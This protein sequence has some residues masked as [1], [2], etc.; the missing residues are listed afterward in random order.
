MSRDLN[1][2]SHGTKGLGTEPLCQL[3]AGDWHRTPT[4][5]IDSSAFSCLTMILALTSRIA[6]PVF[7]RS[8]SSVVV[9]H[10]LCYVAVSKNSVRYGLLFLVGA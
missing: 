7:R 1:D 4:L 6:E 3:R 5:L 10:L 9:K 2:R 8:E